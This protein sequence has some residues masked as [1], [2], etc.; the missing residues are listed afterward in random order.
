MA[1]IH[2]MGQFRLKMAQIQAQN[3]LNGPNPG[4]EP[5]E[6]TRIQAQEPLNPVPDPPNG[7]IVA[8]NSP[9]PGRGLRKWADLGIK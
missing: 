9:N 6:M 4:S 1:Q 7:P 5:P 2:H 3:P 8:L